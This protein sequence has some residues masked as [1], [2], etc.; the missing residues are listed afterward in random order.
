MLTA[1]L[2]RADV[3]RHLQALHL[4]QALREGLAAHR[5]APLDPPPGIPEGITPA[6]RHASLPGFPAWSLTVRSPSAKGV[7]S[8]LQ[9]HDAQ[10]GALL[11]VM[12]ASHLSALR[13]SVVAALS[14]D[15]LARPDAKHVAVLGLGSSASTALKTLRLVRSI[16]QVW[17]YEPNVAD[18]FALA[19]KLQTS[20]SM[21]IRAANSVQEAVAQA[22]VV[23]MTGD[24]ALGSATLAPGAHVAVLDGSR[25]REPPLSDFTLRRAQR[26][27]D[28]LNGMDWGA[29]FD[30]TLGA[31]IAGE[32]AGR[33]N[34]DALTCFVSAAPAQWDLLAAWHVYEGARH[35]ET[36]TRLE[37]DA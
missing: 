31:V 35:D 24:V 29:P 27:G 9:L 32:A 21:A 28:R 26:F 34:A 18:N 3:A 17:M 4:L 8:L 15:V 20:L 11:S 13:A 12:E 14:T 30:V 1:L 37:L 7:R 23:L 25:F 5:N 10:N 19:H 22:D 16:E 2:T 6:T 36:L 33:S